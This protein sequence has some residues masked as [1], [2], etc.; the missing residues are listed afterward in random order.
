L[1]CLRTRVFAM[2]LASC[3][4]TCTVDK[5]FNVR[6]KIQHLQTADSFFILDFYA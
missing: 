6:V 4:L 5:H 1:I 3:Y 2:T